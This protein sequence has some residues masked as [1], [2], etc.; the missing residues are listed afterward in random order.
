MTAAIV[1]QRRDDPLIICYATQPKATQ[2]FAWQIRTVPNHAVRNISTCIL[3]TGGKIMKRWVVMLSSVILVGVLA[4]VGIV[5]WSAR[6][7]DL[8]TDDLH[9]LGLD[10]GKGRVIGI[11][12]DKEEFLPQGTTPQTYEGASIRIHKAVQ[13]GTYKLSEEEPERILYE[14]GEIVAEVKSG[15]DGHWQVDLEPGKYFIRAFYGERSYSGDMFIE[16]QE[17]GVQHLSLELMHGV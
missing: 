7:K 12:T 2:G 3:R 15:K 16:V 4:Y 14:V 11:V 5:L 1:W 8:G 6:P 9:R 17:G 13:A 10:P